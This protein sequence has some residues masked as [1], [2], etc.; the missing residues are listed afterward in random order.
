MHCFC[1]FSF[2]F[3]GGREWDSG[4]GGVFSPQGIHAKT[5]IKRIWPREEAWQSISNV[6][7]KQ[8]ERY[9]LRF[10]QDLGKIVAKTSSSS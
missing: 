6:L 2:N 5:V 10:K 3:S 9:L 8:S 4:G 1:V 7:K